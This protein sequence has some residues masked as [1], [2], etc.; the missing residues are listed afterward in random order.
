[1][2]CRVSATLLSQLVYHGT[3]L[4]LSIHYIGVGGMVLNSFSDRV[5]GVC[6]AW[7]GA[8]GDRQTAALRVVDA[9]A[10]R[11]GV[12]GRIRRPHAARPARHLLPG[13]AQ[14]RPGRVVALL[15]GHEEAR[16]RGAMS[17][18]A[19]LVWMIP[20]SADF[21]QFFSFDSTNGR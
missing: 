20:F 8:G 19:H 7:R 13:R 3:E 5:D 2:Q 17:L 12:A 1:M 16:R 9:A 10:R 18:H 21:I 6:W 4:F 11:E 15:R 14:P